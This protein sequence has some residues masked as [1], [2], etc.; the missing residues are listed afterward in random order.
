MMALQPGAR[1]VQ[2]AYVAIAGGASNT[3]TTPEGG[4]YRS[5]DG[6]KSWAKLAAPNALD[7]G[8]ATAVLQP[9]EGPLYA[10]YVSTSGRAELWCTAD[11]VKW[12]TA[13]LDEDP[14]P[15]GIRAARAAEKAAPD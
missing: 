12:K 9:P 4:I 6:G 5:N 2:S 13:C 10:G 11:G 3:S 7:R 8:A 1:P 14:D 15:T